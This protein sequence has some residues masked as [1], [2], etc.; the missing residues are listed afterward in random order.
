MLK[1]RRKSRAKTTKKKAR[2]PNLK[3][4]TP[5]LMLLAMGSAALLL[6]F[7]KPDGSRGME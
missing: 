4:W 6:H 2:M 3:L 1:K 7:R 5:W